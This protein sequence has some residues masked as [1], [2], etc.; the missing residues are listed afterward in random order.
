MMSFFKAVPLHNYTIPPAGVR[1]GVAMASCQWRQTCESVELR[2]VSRR[3]SLAGLALLP[4][5]RPLPR[6]NQT[7]ERQQGNLSQRE[8]ER[9]GREGGREG[10]SGRGRGREKEENSSVVQIHVI[11]HLSD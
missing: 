8:R 3:V 4:W 9:E 6:R 5:P 7:E 2:L 11:L 10:G 1:G